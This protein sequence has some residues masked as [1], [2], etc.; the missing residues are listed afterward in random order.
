[1]GGAPTPAAPASSSSSS[2]AAAAG[3]ASLSLSAPGPSRRTSRSRT[4]PR[5]YLA[6]DCGGTKAAAVVCDGSGRVRGRGFGGPANYTDV[7]LAA[8]L[9]SVDCAV[10][11]AEQLDAARLSPPTGVAP[12][13]GSP[14]PFEAAWF[15]IAGVDSAADVTALSPH[16]AALLGLP[17]PS[18][19]L[20]VA[21]DTSLLAAPVTDPAH[22][23]IRS[24]VVVIAGTGS[25]VMSFGQS[26]TG[27]L[28]TLGRV[29][30]FGWLLGD[31]GS[32]YAVG[33]D[34]V[35]LV[36]DQADRE[37][38][39]AEPGTS[40][41]SP[42]RC[43]EEQVETAEHRLRDRILKHWGLSS[44]DDLLNAVYSNDTPPSFPAIGASAAPSRKHRLA[45]L[46]P[47]VFHLAFAHTDATCLAIL[48]RQ[49]RAIAEQV[50]EVLRPG[51]SSAAHLRADRS[52]LCCGG[53]LVGVARYRAVLEEELARLGVVF[54][55]VEYVGD[56]AMRGAAALAGVWEAKQTAP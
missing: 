37:R 56:P 29:G 5:L 43:G 17:Y 11:P 3:V 30:G 21:N 12:A 24:G 4:P 53:S 40:S 55:R 14:A 42:V 10:P 31:E 28:K 51:P 44:T 8:F 26:D 47:L 32:G 45:S 2:S 19:R 54:A 48:R 39:L 27:L 52:V 9:R 46:A 16:L 23:H 50:C 38:L 36:L 22:A 7:G 18:P 49:A 15:G 20:I 13:D 1:M 35:R 34:A 33:R 6:V 25:I 41:C